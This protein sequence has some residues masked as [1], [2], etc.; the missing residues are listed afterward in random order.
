M[1]DFDFLH[2]KWSVANRKLK[3]R[4][5]GSSEWLEFPGTAECWSLFGGAAN[6]DEITFPTENVSGLTLR[7]YDP[8]REEWSLYWAS[9]D[10]GTLFPPVVGRFSGGTGTFYGDDTQDGTP[11]RVRYIWSGITPTSARWE[12]AF[13]VDG[14][15]TW[16]TNW[17]MDFT[18]R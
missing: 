11:V 1:H 14:K 12:Q 8:R 4:L 10:G 18:R 6:V 16:E 5:T 13:S 3:E 2:G 7:L 9:S 17:L 15:R